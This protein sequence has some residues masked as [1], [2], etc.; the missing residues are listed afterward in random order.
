MANCS[1]YYSELCDM[2][3]DQHPEEEV[4]GYFFQ[5]GDGLWQ[6]GLRSRG[7][8]HC[9]DFARQFG[10]GGHARAAGYVRAWSPW[11]QFPGMYYP[12]SSA[13]SCL[14]EGKIVKRGFTR[15]AE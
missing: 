11:S 7:D 15:D 14:P 10:G 6:F 9:G 3:L 2:Y 5:R 4:A 1:L 12:A 8:F 13:G